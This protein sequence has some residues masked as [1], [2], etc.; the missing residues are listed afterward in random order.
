MLNTKYLTSIR[1]LSLSN[2]ARKEIHIKIG[3]EEVKWSLIADH[4]I[5]YKTIKSPPKNLL[6]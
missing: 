6:E 3:G 5:L 2:K 4:T 1:S